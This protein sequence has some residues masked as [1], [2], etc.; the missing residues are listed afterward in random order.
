MVRSIAFRS[1]TA[2]VLAALAL[3]ALPAQAQWKWRDAAGHVQYSDLPPPLGTPDKDILTRPASQKR[4]SQP[5]P[6][7]ASSA[8]AAASDALL[9][10]TSDPELEARRKKAEADQ[11]AKAKAD[12]ARNAAI[13]ADNCARAQTQLKT[14]DSGIRVARLNAKGEREYLDDTQRASETKQAR[15]AIA[16]NCR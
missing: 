16:S 13:K 8:S 11:A 9:V 15:D 12:E 5:L 10:K 1:V 3:L 7:A 2:G 6:G 4:V 14:F